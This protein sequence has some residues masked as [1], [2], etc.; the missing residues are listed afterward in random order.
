[1]PFKK[2][3]NSMRQSQS[4]SSKSAN[5]TS[6]KSTYKEVLEGRLSDSETDD[7]PDQ[8]SSDIPTNH[9]QP[10]SG[11]AT[12]NN[13]TASQVPHGIVQDT[14]TTTLAPREWDS[15]EG[16]NEFLQSDA[17]SEIRY[18]RC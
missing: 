16:R 4:A 6:D 17:F 2:K 10:V 13:I 15:D 7:P 18:S 14:A 11:T 8:T 1:M 3:T 9:Q 12:V 5:R